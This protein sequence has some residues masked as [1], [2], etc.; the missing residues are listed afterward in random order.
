[1]IRSVSKRWWIDAGVF[2]TGESRGKMF[3]SVMYLF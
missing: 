3:V 1:M 2:V